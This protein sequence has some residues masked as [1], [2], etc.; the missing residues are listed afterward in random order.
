M[1]IKNEPWINTDKG[2][3]YAAHKENKGNE[4]INKMNKREY[5]QMCKLQA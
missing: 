4:E 1:P 5:L 2:K 3:Y